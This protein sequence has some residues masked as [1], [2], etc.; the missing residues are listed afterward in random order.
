MLW[1]IVTVAH[2]A[3]C[4]MSALML[5]AFISGLAYYAIS[6]PGGSK[7]LFVLLAV[8]TFG[9][10]QILGAAYYEIF[11]RRLVRWWPA[12]SGGVEPPF[13]LRFIGALVLC[14][15]L[16]WLLY[17]TTPPAETIRRLFLGE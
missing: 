6:R 5:I 16:A 17:L 8:L 1:N 12:Y 13:A 9:S 14:F 3:I 2:K 15:S 10:F 4:A 7:G 11:G